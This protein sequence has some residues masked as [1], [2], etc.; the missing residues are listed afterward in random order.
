[1]LVTHDEPAD[2]G[3]ET[4]QASGGCGG[5]VFGAMGEEM[6]AEEQVGFKADGGEAALEEERIEVAVVI[7]GDP[8]E[9]DGG[10][11]GDE[12]LELI[13]EGGDGN[14]AVDDVAQ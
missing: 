9:G 13:A 3:L 14:G 11:A 8:A 12:G 2:A 1:M 10:K 5:V 7:A 6:G 4:L